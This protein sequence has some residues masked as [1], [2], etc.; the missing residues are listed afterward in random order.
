MSQFLEL[1][2]DVFAAVQDAAAEAGTTPATWVAAKLPPRP[3]PSDAAPAAGAPPRTLADLLAGRI[4]S[5]KG[6]GV[7][8][9]SENAGEQFADYLVAKHRGGAP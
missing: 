7:N 9:S 2:D 8:N 6:T 4:G 3:A 5:V 1:P